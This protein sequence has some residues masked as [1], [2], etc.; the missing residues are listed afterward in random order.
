[1]TTSFAVALS[2]AASMSSGIKANFGTMAK[3][4]HVGHCTRN[5][6]LAALMA[7]RGR[8]GRARERWSTGRASSRCSTAP[9]TTTPSSLLAGWADT[10]RHRRDR[11][12]IQAASVLRQ[13]PPGGRRDAGAARHVRADTR[14]RQPCRILDASAPLEAHQ[15]A[16]SEDRPRRQILGAIRARARAVPKASSTSACSRD[17]SRARARDPRCDDEGA[18]AGRPAGADGYDRALLRHCPHHD[19]GGR[20]AT[21]PSSTARSAATATI[22]CPTVRSRPSSS[23][24]RR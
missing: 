18:L 22:R 23:I 3:P 20:C 16:R 10:A 1:M 5:G 6:L 8:D 12:R 24:V 13:H 14:Q 21:R 2:L 15:P 19:D 17:V 7:E 4:F 11:R 9:A